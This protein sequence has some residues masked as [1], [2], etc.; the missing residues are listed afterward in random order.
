MNKQ[1]LFTT[2]RSKQ[3]QPGIVCQAC[4]ASMVKRTGRYGSFWGCTR[5]PECRGTRP[6]K[7]D[8][9]GQSCRH[10]GTPVVRRTHTKLPKPGGCWRSAS[11]GSYFAWWFRCP[12]YKAIYLVEAARRFFD[13]AGTVEPTS[14]PDF[15]P[16]WIAREQ[17]TLPWQ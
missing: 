4:G 12:A 17:A 14:A 2:A 11:G 7:I 8:H 10:C 1:E 16:D 13:A 5:Y 15:L 9:E 6:F 3:N